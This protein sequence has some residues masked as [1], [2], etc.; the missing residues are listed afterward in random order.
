M[1]TREVRLEYAGAGFCEIVR[2]GDIV[3]F[4]F[5]N[6][7]D[8]LHKDEQITTSLALTGP[9]E[10]DVEITYVPLKR[11]PWPLPMRPDAKD[12]LGD[13]AEQVKAFIET[14]IDL[15]DNRLYD[16]LSAWVMATWVPEV[17][18]SVPYLHIIGPKSSGKTRLLEVLQALCY[19]AILSANIS[20]SAVFR[21]VQSF[22]P[23][24]L[25][26]E[27]EIYTKESRESIQNLLNAGYRR[28]QVAIRIGKDTTT[29]TPKLE[30]FEVFGFKALAGTGGYKDTL[31][32]RSIRISMERNIREVGLIIDQNLATRIRTRLLLWRW[33]FLHNFS[34]NMSEFYERA[35]NSLKFCN[36]RLLELFTPL[37]IIS[38]YGH[39]NIIDYVKEVLGDLREEEAT[40]VE[41]EI[42][43]CL[44]EIKDSLKSGKFATK[45]LA[46]LF[47]ANRSD[48]EKWKT[49]SLGNVLKRLGFKPTRLTNGERGYIFDEAKVSRLALRYGFNIRKEASLASLASLRDG[50]NDLE[51]DLKKD[52]L[53]EKDEKKSFSEGQ[54]KSD[55]SDASD[56]ALGHSDRPSLSESLDHFQD[57]CLRIKLSEGLQEVSRDYLFEKTKERFQWDRDLF[58]RVLKVALRDRVFV[59]QHS[60]DPDLIILKWR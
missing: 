51:N 46:D 32:S 6:G 13:L 54:N 24:L 23:T 3:R 59:E 42:V 55:A 52:V 41:A 60:L 16:V 20:E 31:E 1:K 18:V 38:N 56:L 8:K 5:Y 19:R 14:Y 50:Q 47:N 34:Q 4:C 27:A 2:D 57:V 17:W 53:D 12:T 36:G 48:N 58:N 45:Y 29:E 44:L 37:V 21:S 40:S 39:E 25:L 30:L 11:I 49:Q 10:G 7:P 9:S 28:G 33:R 22:K 26:D 15:Q 43:G 35:F